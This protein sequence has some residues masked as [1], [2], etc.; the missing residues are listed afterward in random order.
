MYAHGLDFDYG[1][2]EKKRGYYKS[3]QSFRKVIRGVLSANW[4]RGTKQ[5]FFQCLSLRVGGR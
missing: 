4:G 5:N 3:G 1:R 2:D